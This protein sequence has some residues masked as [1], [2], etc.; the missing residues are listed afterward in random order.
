MKRTFFALG[1][2]QLVLG[3]GGY[4]LPHPFHV[5][6]INVGDYNPHFVRDVASV[7]VAIGA[8]TL[9]GAWRP[10]WR[11]PSVI[12]GVVAYGGNVVS[13]L[14]ALDF[15]DGDVPAGSLADLLGHAIWTGV[16]IALIPAL[17]GS[18]LG[19]AG[20]EL[21]RDVVRSLRLEWGARPEPDQARSS[22]NGSR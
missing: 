3:V 6:I 7:Y 1:L 16:L 5:S 20:R 13:T 22:G 21:A 10:S 19:V 4:L 14:L 12:L 18:S 8:G 2:V 15:A 11:L 9:V 17:S